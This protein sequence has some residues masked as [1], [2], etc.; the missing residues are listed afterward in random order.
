MNIHR[1]L[2]G[3]INDSKKGINRRSLNLCS[4]SA[5]SQEDYNAV[6][7]GLEKIIK[8]TQKTLVIKSLGSSLWIKGGG[9]FSSPDWYQS[10]SLTNINKGY[11][12]QVSG[13]SIFEL[14]LS[15]PWQKGNPH[16]DFFIC[17]MDMTTYADDKGNNFIFGLGGYPVNVISVKRINAW[18]EDPGLRYKALAILA[19]HEFA[20][21][22]NLVKRD[23]TNRGTGDYLRH[24]CLGKQGTCLMEQIN[25]HDCKNLELQGEI[26]FP[27]KNW[28]CPDCSEELRIRRAYLKS[29]GVFY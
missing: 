16:F 13:N 18:T 11:G 28:L 19:A 24:H 15:E 7:Y 12:L 5:V 21:D 4:T 25:L 14:L 2:E 23:G 26:L 17:D 10:K 1:D 27:I 6:L 8:E 9:D 20:H 22:L 3:A 29:N